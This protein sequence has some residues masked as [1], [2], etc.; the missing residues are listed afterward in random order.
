MATGKGRE[1]AV[2][3]SG[4][5]RRRTRRASG[6]A[7]RELGFRAAVN[8]ARGGRRGLRGFGGR[9]LPRPARHSF[10]LN[11]APGPAPPPRPA[12]IDL[13]GRPS[14]GRG[15]APEVARGRGATTPGQRGLGWP[16]LSP[17]AAPQELTEFSTAQE[18]RD[19]M[20]FQ[21]AGALSPVRALTAAGRSAACPGCPTPLPRPYSLPE[22]LHSPSFPGCAFGPGDSPGG[23]EPGTQQGHLSHWLNLAGAFCQEP[24]EGSEHACP[25]D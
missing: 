5:V 8:E 24:Q 18:G 17:C 9:G 16:P 4:W 3:G 13:G 23:S 19:A 10:P 2:G 7:E 1:A 20:P 6:L 12:R 14:S 21:R 15:T 25:S 22:T 11:R